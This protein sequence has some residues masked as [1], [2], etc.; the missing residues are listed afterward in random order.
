MFAPDVS[1]TF[2]THADLVHMTSLIQAAGYKMAAC[3][4]GR[5]FVTVKRRLFI[6]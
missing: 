4:H 2:P 5:V 1:D 3:S 6:N